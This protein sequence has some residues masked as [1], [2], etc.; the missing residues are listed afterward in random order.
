MGVLR[1]GVLITFANT[2]LVDDSCFYKKVACPKEVSVFFSP[3]ALN[4][5]CWITDLSGARISGRV[6]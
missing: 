6:V 4:A 2:A 1:M 5:H 3:I